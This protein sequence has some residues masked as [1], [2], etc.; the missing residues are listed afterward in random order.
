MRTLWL[1]LL[2]SSTLLV[3]AADLRAQTKEPI[4]PF[5]IDARIVLP[6]FKED[7]NLA[8]VLGV[9]STNLPTR[10]LGLAGGAHWYPAHLGQVTL[11]VGGE[12][13][14]SRGSNTLEPATAGGLEGPTVNTRFSALTPQISLNFGTGRGWSYLTGGLGWGSFRTE[15]ADA[16]VADADSDPR[17][18]HYGGGA[19]WFAKKHLAF[20]LDLRFYVVNAQPAAVG[21]PGYP[22]MT[23]MV[24]SGGV[25]FK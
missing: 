10:G 23:L 18:L 16:P 13:I 7:A 9:S 14:I 22:A 3:G 6:R 1:L 2:S 5:V 8:G 15:R 4:G 12:V 20:A 24:F 17:V 19:R 21:R 11:G 25:S